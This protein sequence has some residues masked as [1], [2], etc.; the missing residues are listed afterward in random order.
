MTGPVRCGHQGTRSYPL[1]PLG[2]Y[3]RWGLVVPLLLFAKVHNQLLC[4]ADIQEEVVL[5]LFGD[6]GEDN[7]VEFMFVS[8]FTFLDSPFKKNW[9]LDFW[10]LVLLLTLIFGLQLGLCMFLCDFVS[11]FLPDHLCFFL[12]SIWT[13]TCVALHL[14]LST[15]NRL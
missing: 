7:S 4:F 14:S 11:G 13:S 8:T 10:I 15:P 3:S 12:Y 6:S 2:S 1:C 9:F 5:Q